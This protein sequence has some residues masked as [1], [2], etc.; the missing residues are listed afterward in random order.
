LR[1][2]TNYSIDGLRIDTFHCVKGE[3]WT[4]YYEA[5]GVYSVGEVDSTN[6]SYVGSWQHYGPDVLSYPLFWHLRWVFTEGKSSMKLLYQLYQQY[7]QVFKDVTTLATFTDNHDN[8][9]FLSLTN[10]PPIYR[11]ALAYVLMSVG[12][13][14]VYYGSEQGYDS[15]QDP[16]SREPLWTSGYNQSHPYFLFISTLTHYR[17]AVQLGYY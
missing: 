7:Q 1:C 16:Y 13:P 2:Y 3:F 14:I 9:R 5:A 6:T 10:D 17:K 4:E 15:S 11:S 12:V 8:P